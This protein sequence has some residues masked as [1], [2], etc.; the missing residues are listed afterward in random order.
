MH[1]EE[2]ALVQEINESIYLA[3]SS[4]SKLW[5]LSGSSQES[6]EGELMGYIYDAVWLLD[7]LKETYEKK[8]EKEN[9]E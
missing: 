3:K 4:A 9:G 7:R 8:E 6:L 2:R 1:E 5:K